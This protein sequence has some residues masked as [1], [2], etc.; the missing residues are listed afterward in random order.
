MVSP[1]A[2]V[3]QSSIH[4]HSKLSAPFHSARQKL[5]SMKKLLKELLISRL[6]FPGVTPERETEAVRERERVAHSN[7]QNVSQGPG[8]LLSINTWSIE[9]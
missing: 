9:N 7:M 4:H 2:R 3:D 6:H 5:I 1:T 8:N